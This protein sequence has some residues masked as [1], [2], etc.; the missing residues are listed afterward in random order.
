M[1]SDSRFADLPLGRFAD[2]LAS[3]SPV[4]GGGSSAAVVAALAAGLVAM[5]ARLTRG[6]ERYAE[7]EA[8][9]VEVEAAAEA[10]RA[11][12]LDLADRDAN[13]YGG[14][15]NAR[16]LPRETD[17][18]RAARNAAVAQA[19]AESITA[20]LLVADAAERVTV[21]ARRLAGASNPHAISDV[22]CAAA[23]GSAAVRGAI[24]SVRINLP[25]LANDDP[26]RHEAGREID[27]LLAS[28]A[29]NERAVAELV[30][31]IIE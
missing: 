30:E 2:E 10:L 14:L 25:G 3:D 7:H 12:L 20:P 19:T 21:L 31:T 16:R 28:A 26:L 5:V 4:P 29:S 13:A 11:E 22:G 15:L 1:E 6:R 17:D 8:T 23:F 18:E 24:L 9:A 27:R